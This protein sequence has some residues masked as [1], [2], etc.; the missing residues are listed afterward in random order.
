MID[1][2]QGIFFLNSEKN[3]VVRVTNMIRN[4]PSELM[5]FI[6]DQL[7]GIYLV[8]VR[9]VFH[10]SKQLRIGRLSHTLLIN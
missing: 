10:N 1:P 9:T 7:S 6:P 3:D 4:K 2:E 8:E 5:F